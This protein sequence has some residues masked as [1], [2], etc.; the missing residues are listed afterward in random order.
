[1]NRTSNHCTNA[2]RMLALTLLALGTPARAEDDAQF[3]L[4]SVGDVR[5]GPRTSLTYDAIVRSHP[6]RLD[7]GQVLLRGG[8][9]RTLGA[10]A[11]VQFTYGWVRSIVDA[12][13]DVTEHRLGETLAVGIGQAGA[14]R[15]D[16]RVGAEQR[17]PNG[18]GAVGWRLRGRMRATLPLSASA[19]LQ[20]SDEVIGALNDTSWG[21]RAGASANRL[22]SSV[23]WRF[24]P[25]VGIAPGYT[26]QHIF[27]A[28]APDR[29]DHVFSVT[30][31]SHF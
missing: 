9:R 1:M 25:R 10:S 18:G 31:D 30:I 3:W 19:D 6:D 7:A 13:D 24:S 14:V 17:L 12:G 15:V 22:A 28:D 11:S 8:V 27:R 2:A 16:G 26:W 21:Q 4:L 20:L 29:E 23:H 5:V